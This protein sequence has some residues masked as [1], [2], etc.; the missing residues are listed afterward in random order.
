MIDIEQLR[1]QLEPP[2]S[3]ARSTKNMSTQGLSHIVFPKRTDNTSG[4]NGKNRWML[5]YADLMTLLLG[6]FLVM[7]ATQYKQLHPSENGQHKNTSPFSQMHLEGLFTNLESL[8]NLNEKTP[9]ES[10]DAIQWA[11]DKQHLAAK[12]QT[13][14]NKTT[15]SFD[16]KLFFEPGQATL[17]PSAKKTL[18]KIALVL[19]NQSNTS[20][21]TPKI[22]HIRIEGHTDNTPIHTNQFP[23]NW[24]LSTMR[25]TVIL[26][27]LIQAHHFDPRTISAA[28]YGEYSPIASNESDAG[29]RQNRRVD[30]VIE[31]ADSS[32]AKEPLSVI[33]SKQGEVDY[34]TTD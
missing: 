20:N 15:L 10:D 23:S 21:L 22:Q 5:P 3:Q 25:A 19:R 4:Q 14:G 13:S 34:A 11:L 32:P 8:A 24:E 2:S 7:F 28:G 12:I 30:I 26:R 33:D 31:R 29:R 17:T 1:Q 16:E 6:L 18:A 27:D 9:E